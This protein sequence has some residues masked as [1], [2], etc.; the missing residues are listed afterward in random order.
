MAAAV[1]IAVAVAVSYVV[2]A[3][4][5]AE[6]ADVLFFFGLAATS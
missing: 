2:A 1:D 4:E 5:A 6:A 3:S